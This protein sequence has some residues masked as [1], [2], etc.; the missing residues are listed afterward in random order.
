MLGSSSTLTSC[1]LNSTLFINIHSWSS[2]QVHCFSTSMFINNE[3][4]CV[5]FLSPMCLSWKLMSQSCLLRCWKIFG[6]PVSQFSHASAFSSWAWTTLRSLR[7][8]RLQPCA[9][10]VWGSYRGWNWTAFPSRQKLSGTST[11]SN[12]FLDKWTANDPF[13]VKF[14]GITVVVIALDGF[15][16]PHICMMSSSL[17]KCTVF[18]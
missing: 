14:I 11:V 2:I 9:K 8:T 17:I 5:R 15:V 1:R 10:Q 12:P 18:T 16:S 6:L 4:L 3:I 7:T 13:L